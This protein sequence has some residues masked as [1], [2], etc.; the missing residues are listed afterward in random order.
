[1]RCETRNDKRHVDIEHASTPAVVIKHNK[2]WDS[3]YNTPKDG[4]Y[5]VSNFWDSTVQ[6]LQSIRL[7]GAQLHVF[8][9]VGPGRL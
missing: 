4:G 5:W 6:A 1:M 9:Q 7:R 8:H 2:C 3:L